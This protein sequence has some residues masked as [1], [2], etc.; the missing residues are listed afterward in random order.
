MPPG[1]LTFIGG[2]VA[3]G[4]LSAFVLIHQ[5]LNDEPRAAEDSKWTVDRTNLRLACPPEV[6]IAGLLT[7][8]R[9]E[10]K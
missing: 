9:E 5:Y 3:F 10:L 4:V 6:E 1:D 2:L 7:G 8:P